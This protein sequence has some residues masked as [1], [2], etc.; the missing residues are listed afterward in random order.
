MF[1]GLV[2]LTDAG[3]RVKTLLKAVGAALMSQWQFNCSSVLT[4]FADLRNPL[5][6]YAPWPFGP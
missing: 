5:S 4:E 2:A 3:C 1:S 6:W